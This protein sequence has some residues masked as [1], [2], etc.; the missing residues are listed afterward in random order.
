MS[1]PL[2]KAAPAPGQ[3][4]K[5]VKDDTWALP[6]SIAPCTTRRRRRSRKAGGKQVRR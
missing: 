4:R 1:E 3:T 5:G 2:Y 6:G